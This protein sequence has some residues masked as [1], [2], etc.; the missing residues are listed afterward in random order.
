MRVSETE[1]RVKA[2]TAYTKYKSMLEGE[3][4]DNVVNEYDILDHKVMVWKQGI[5]AMERS[6]KALKQ[7]YNDEIMFSKTGKSE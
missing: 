1:L 5:A 2:T 4:R 6:L 7:S 3:A